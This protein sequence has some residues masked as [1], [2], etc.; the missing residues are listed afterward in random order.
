[1]LFWMYSC[2]WSESGCRG[3]DGSWER[4]RFLLMNS[5]SSNPPKRPVDT[6]PLPV[7]KA[8]HQLRL[9]ALTDK[10][11]AVCSNSSSSCSAAAATVA[12]DLFLPAF[13]PVMTSAFP[14]QTSSLTMH[15]WLND[16]SLLNFLPPSANL[17]PI[18]DKVENLDVVCF[19]AAFALEFFWFL[20]LC[21]TLLSTL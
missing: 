6:T 5:S 1:M 11:A 4:L 18:A 9:R 21:L 14:L 13:L 12:P 16:S 20:G 17:P 10:P 15:L 7:N 3:R 19:S 8:S 2:H